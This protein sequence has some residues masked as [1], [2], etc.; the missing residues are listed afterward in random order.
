MLEG[1]E[2]SDAGTSGEGNEH[3]GIAGDRHGV[4]YEKQ[5][6][7]ASHDPRGGGMSKRD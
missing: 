5:E 6:Q 4:A 7:D 2:P 3:T 1:K